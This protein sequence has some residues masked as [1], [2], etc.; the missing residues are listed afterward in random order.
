MN[1]TSPTIAICGAGPTG[2]AL[3]ALLVKQGL[4][5]KSITLLDTKPALDLT[6]RAQTASDPRSIALSQG[7][8]Q[9]LET[10]GAWPIHSTA[11]QQIHISR[12]GHFGRTLL[13]ATEYNLPAL[14]YVTRYATLVEALNNTTA[15]SGVKTIHAAQVA[16]LEEHYQ[17][18]NIH[19]A[20]GSSVSADIVIQAEGGQ[21]GEQAMKKQS[22]DYHQT[23]IVAQVAVTAPIMHRAFERF[24]EEG[25]IALLPHKGEDNTLGARPDSTHYSLVWCV[26]PATA[27]KL[28]ALADEAF[29]EALGEAFGTRLGTFRYVSQRNTYPL[30]LNAYPAVTQRT[31]AI[32]NASQTLH[33][34]A[35]Q[36]LN[37]GLRDAAVLARCLSQQV[38]PSALQRFQKERRIDRKM[39]VGITDLMARVFASTPDGSLPQTILGLSLGLIDSITPVRKLLADQ[40]MFGRR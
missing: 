3:A 14:G 31:V 2:L 6:T 13:D 28:I 10:I 12:R 20:S 1:P 7:S 22:R 21:F 30:G 33:P 4:N 34:V 19:L 17:N 9:L 5:P 18:V 25:P 36:G 40:M 27:A 32:G 8:A 24:T 16:K 39:T 15:R 37:L 23:A 38:S 11:I 29:L 35:G 26:R